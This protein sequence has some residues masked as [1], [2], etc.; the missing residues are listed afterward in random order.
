MNNQQCKIRPQII[1]INTNEDSFYH[2][3]VKIT[4]SSGSCNNFNDAFAKLGVP[5]VVKN[6]N[7][8]VLNLISRTH[9]T[10]HIEWYGTCKCKLD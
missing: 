9:E 10:R 4:K 5:Y 3:N 7:V 8:R 6:I 2:H 1:N